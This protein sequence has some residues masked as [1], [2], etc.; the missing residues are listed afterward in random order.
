MIRMAIANSIVPADRN[1]NSVSGS[2]PQSY[3]LVRCASVAIS[4]HQPIE[5]AAAIEIVQNFYC[6][7]HMQLVGN[8]IPLY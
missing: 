2:I 5:I 7:I 4:G 1:L 3:I 8:F 6:I